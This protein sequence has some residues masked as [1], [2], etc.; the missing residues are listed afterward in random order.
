ML[1][2]RAMLC[3]TSTPAAAAA[4]AATAAF[5][6]ET[7]EGRLLMASSVAPF[8]IVAGGTGSLDVSEIRT[9]RNGTIF[10]GGTFRGLIDFNPAQGAM[11]ASHNQSND[12]FLAA[13]SSAGSFLWVQCFGGAGDEGIDALT[14]DPLTGNVVT[15]GHFTSRFNLLVGGIGTGVPAPRLTRISPA[16]IRDTFLATFTPAG[17]GASFNQFGKTGSMFVE[18]V[19]VGPLSGMIALAGSF[20]GS[21]DADPTTRQSLVTGPEGQEAGFLLTLSARRRLF[22]TA[23]AKDTDG[24][25][26]FYDA[27]FDPT[28]EAVVATGAAEGDFIIATAAGDSTV[29]TGA[30]F[31]AAAIKFDRPGTLAWSKHVTST[32]LTA[33]YGVAVDRG[34]SVYWTGEF[35]GTA[36]LDT[37]ANKKLVTQPTAT[38]TGSTFLSKL[39]TNGTFLWGNAVG[40]S[41]FVLGQGISFNSDGN[42]AITG[43]FSA[44]ADFNPNNSRLDLTARPATTSTGGT[45]TGID[46][47]KAEYRIS[48]GALI[49]ATR[50]GTAFREFAG[51]ITADG[52]GF[53]YTDLEPTT[54]IKRTLVLR[55]TEA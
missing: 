14:L 55:W 42:V 2:L 44:T 51:T 4:A 20:D 15:A 40:G 25:T 13:Y 38:S 45:T 50:Y 34:G 8:P 7:L 47:F 18:D 11:R 26:N 52:K 49:G 41:G 10:V 33:G 16:G 39:S 17:V 22:W 29:R 36:D 28:N 6:V 21:F 3:T 35:D 53:L 12:A 5:N 9:A 37:G 19:E 46:V 27:A 43:A 54:G 32:D 30:S 24:Q 23:T 1:P 48:T 31:S